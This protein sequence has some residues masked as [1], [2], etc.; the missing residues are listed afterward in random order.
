[1]EVNR[2]DLETQKEL[3]TAKAQASLVRTKA[4]AEARLIQ[5]QAGINGTRMLLDKVGINTQ[6]HINAYNYIKTLRDRGQLDMTV[7]YLSEDSV[8]RT[9]PV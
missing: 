2:I 1:M 6:N 8:V 3:R 4:V 7:S 5:A 9:A